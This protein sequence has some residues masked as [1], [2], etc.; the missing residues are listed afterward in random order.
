MSEQIFLSLIFCSIIPSI[1][2]QN[3]CDKQYSNQLFDTVFNYNETVYVFRRPNSFW[4]LHFDENTGYW[5]QTAGPIAKSELF[6]GFDER[7]I[8]DSIFSISHYTKCRTTVE[9]CVNN[10]RNFDP[11]NITFVFA[12]QM[13]LLFR[14]YNEKWFKKVD[15]SEKMVPWGTN[16]QLQKTNH[17]I[18][19]LFK[20]VNSRIDGAAILEADENWPEAVMILVDNAVK[21]FDIIDTNRDPIG[22]IYIQDDNPSLLIKNGAINHLEKTFLFMGGMVWEYFEHSSI[23]NRVSLRFI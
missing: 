20:G 10:N 3:F 23:E 16:W 1:V 9:F 8:F 12:D 6:D 17:K 13:Y 21:E 7:L 2:S 14:R 22:T 18:S 4:I 15:E 11:T 19:D 5:R